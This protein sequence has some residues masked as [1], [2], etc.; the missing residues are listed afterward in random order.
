MDKPVEA[1]DTVREH[2]Q[3]SRPICIVI[4][5]ILPAITA[6]GDVI[7]RS[8]VF[9]AKGASHEVAWC[10]NVRVDQYQRN[11]CTEQ[12]LTPLPVQHSQNERDAGSGQGAETGHQGRPNNHGLAAQR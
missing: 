2:R 3:K 10:S 6:G 11:L 8:C 5:N 4:N 7:Q 1:L 9:D 12:D